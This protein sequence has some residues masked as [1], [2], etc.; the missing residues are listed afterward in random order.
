MKKTDVIEYLKSHKYK[1]AT[2]VGFLSSATFETLL[3]SNDD[4]E[5]MRDPKELLIPLGV[6]LFI[7][8][9]A[10][11]NLDEEEREPQDREKEIKRIN[12]K[13]YK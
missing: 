13:V 10:G 11:L 12:Q 9:Y 3:I 8:L 2:Y 5:N 4:V 1:L 6:P 7:M